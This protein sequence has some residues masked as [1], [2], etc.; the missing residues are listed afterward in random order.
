MNA[1]SKIGAKM[2]T[3]LMRCKPV[4]KVARKV[5]KNKPEIMAVS[6]G[7]LIVGAF[8]WAIYEAV[9]LKDTLDETSD[10]VKA[11]EASYEREL[12]QE[13]L[14]EEKRTD[15]QKEYKK[16]L[17][18]ARFKG[19]M[20]VG[21]KFVLPTVTLA[22]GMGVGAKGFKLLR[23]RNIMLGT[24][25][26]GSQE[27][28]KFYRENVRADLGEEADRKYAHGIVGEKEI[29]E[30]VKD[31]KGNETKV[32]KK[33]PVARTIPN[34]PW[35]FEYSDTWFNTCQESSDSNIFFLKCQAEYFTKQLNDHGERGISMYDVL[36]HC[37]YKFDVLKESLS[38]KEYKKRMDFLRNNGWWKGSGGDGFVDL[39]VY[40]DINEP[41]I[42]R[43]SNVVFIEMNCDGP[44]FE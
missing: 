6:S 41:A 43:R 17:T 42:M 40:R 22:V 5:S 21:K 18:K 12:A 28:Y 9:G 38:P 44:L 32:K 13:D 35:R 11:V 19:V 26:K 24:A 23:A 2:G 20:K 36:V 25:L 34:N 8:A 10:T 7:I 14:T 39:G 4:A 30:V 3:A 33:V 16:E 31:E 15:I 27:A 29:E 1:L 37:G